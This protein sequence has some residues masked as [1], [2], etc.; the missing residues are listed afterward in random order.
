[1]LLFGNGER[2]MINQTEKIGEYLRLTKEIDKLT[3]ELGGK[4]SAAKSK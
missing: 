1:M 2:F 3:R 4:E